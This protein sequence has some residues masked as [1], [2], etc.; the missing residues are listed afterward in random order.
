MQKR[1]SQGLL[2]TYTYKSHTINGFVVVRGLDAE[3]VFAEEEEEE[4]V[5]EKYVVVHL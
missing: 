4:V 3:L 1:S 2:L 5:I